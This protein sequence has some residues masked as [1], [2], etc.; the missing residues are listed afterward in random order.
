MPPVSPHCISASLCPERGNGGQR[1]GVLL[2]INITAYHKTIINTILC[3]LKNVN[4][5]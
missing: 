4:E 2:Y 1:Q 5:D 3:R